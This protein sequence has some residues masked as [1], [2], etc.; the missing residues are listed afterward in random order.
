MALV[1]LA[2]VWYPALWL[3]AAG[4]LTPPGSEGGGA[5]GS[6]PSVARLLLWTFLGV[7][8]LGLPICA[9]L[10]ARRAWLGWLLVV[11]VL[12]GF[13]LAVI[14]WMFGIL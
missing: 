7:A 14:L 9:L 11:L 4:L 3:I 1:S 2:M 12:S 5:P 6:G 10:M 13:A 8:C